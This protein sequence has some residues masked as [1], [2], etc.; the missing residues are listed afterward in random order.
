[1]WVSMELGNRQIVIGY[2][3]DFGQREFRFEHE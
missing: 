3:D 2:D 1:M